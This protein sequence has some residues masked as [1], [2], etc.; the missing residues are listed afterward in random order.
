MTTTMGVLALAGAVLL[1]ATAVVTRL[2]AS[3][4]GRRTGRGF[5]TCS[6]TVPD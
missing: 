4:W 1:A 3:L 6:S 5:G 2:L